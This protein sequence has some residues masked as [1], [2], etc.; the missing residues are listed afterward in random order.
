MQDTAERAIAEI[1]GIRE[2]FKNHLIEDE[3]R[4]GKI[5]DELAKANGH[6]EEMLDI[7]RAFNLGKSFIIGCSIF[8]GSFIAIVVGLKQILTWLK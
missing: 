7:M 3:K 1:T 5:D 8:I 2:S 6:L 4:F